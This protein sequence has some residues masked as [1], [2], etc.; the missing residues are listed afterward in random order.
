MER[1]SERGRDRDGIRRVV[2]LDVVY[3]FLF[4]LSWTYLFSD[5]GFDVVLGNEFCEIV[6]EDVGII[7]DKEIERLVGK[8]VIH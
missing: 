7:V 8:V 3:F 6:E 1:E 4:V 2:G 5:R